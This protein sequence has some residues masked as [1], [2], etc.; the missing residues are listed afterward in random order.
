M[1][2]APFTTIR[3][4]RV[5]DGARRRPADASAGAESPA[6]GGGMA[7]SGRTVTAPDEGRLGIVGIFVSAAHPRITGL[8]MGCG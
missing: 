5:A 3:G 8:W 6:A 7:A 2:E 1:S 4:R